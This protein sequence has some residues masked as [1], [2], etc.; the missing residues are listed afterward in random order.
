MDALSGSTP[1]DLA[2]HST[3]TC[4]G[5]G[6]YHAWVKTVRRCIILVNWQPDIAEKEMAMPQTLTRH[7][8]DETIQRY[9]QSATA[10]HK[11]LEDFIVERL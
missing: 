8:P 1:F 7:L 9:Q 5:G 4:A 6:D 3:I 10:A 2:C 11:R